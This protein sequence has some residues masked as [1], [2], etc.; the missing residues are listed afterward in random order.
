VSAHLEY[1]MDELP[2]DESMAFIDKVPSSCDS[3][4]MMFFKSSQLG[5]LNE[6]QNYFVEHKQHE[7]R[8]ID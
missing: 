3:E 6:S 8:A 4:S 2:R 1:N 7:E 5:K